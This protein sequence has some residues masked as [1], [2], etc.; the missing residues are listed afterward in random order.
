MNYLMMDQLWTYGNVM[1]MSDVM[2]SESSFFP[3]HTALTLNWAVIQD[4]SM[5]WIC[6]ITQKFESLTTDPTN[7]VLNSAH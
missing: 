2:T 4:R 6:R 7:N 1:D 5:R 3:F